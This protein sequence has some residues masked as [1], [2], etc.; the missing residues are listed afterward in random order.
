MHNCLWLFQRKATATITTITTIAVFLLPVYGPG[1]KNLE[2]VQKVSPPPAGRL[3]VK[4]P[5]LFFVPSPSLFG[6][7]LIKLI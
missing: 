2:P 3:W 6:A 7:T 1:K 4:M 5:G